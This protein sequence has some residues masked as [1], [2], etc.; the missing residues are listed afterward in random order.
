MARSS[1]VRV[2][3]PPEAAAKEAALQYVTDDR[4]GITRQK[5][6]NG[7]GY[8]DAKGGRVSDRATLDRIRALAVPPAWTDVWIS[9]LP[10]GHIQA[11]GR[12]ARGRKQYRYHARWHAV[13]DENKYA[14]MLQFGDALPALRRQVNRDLARRDLSREKVLAVVIRL[15]ETT[16]IRVGNEEY[17]RAN[18]T[19]GL[20]TLRNQHVQLEGNT[21]RFQFTGKSG[22]AHTIKLSDRRLARVVRQC[23]DLPGQ[24]L[25]QYADDGGQPHTI[26]SADVND[27][28]RDVMGDEFTAKDF[29]TWSGTLLAACQLEST[30]ASNADGAPKAISLAAA[31]RAVSAQLGNTPAVCKQRYIHPTV[32][33]AFSDTSLRARF[34]RLLRT[35]RARAGLTR[36][37]SALLTFLRG[38]TRRAS[39]A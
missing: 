31:L 20:T 16:Y 29:R 23:R 27:Y 17:A 24:A 36:A 10:S 13:R 1:A 19:F 2:S 6:G 33:Q 7:F 3:V 37:E 30:N 5:R 12:D 39:A 32:L 34:T 28:L 18:G 14:R 4:P 25:F 26:D 35:S 8:K 21:M 22:K 11:T 15:L 38:D 9:P